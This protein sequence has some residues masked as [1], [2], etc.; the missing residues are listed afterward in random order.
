MSA[1]AKPRKKKSA[2][3]HG[4]PAHESARGTRPHGPEVH[5][6]NF[7]LNR[8]ER[9]VQE[10]IT[11]PAGIEAGMQTRSARKLIDVPPEELEK[12]ILPS[13]QLSAAERIGIYSS[14]YF[15]RL[16]E[17][18]EKDFEVVRHAVGEKRFTALAG[19]FLGKHPST[20]Y[21]LNKLGEK[22]A[23]FLRKEV[24]TLPHRSFIVEVAILERTIQDLFDERVATPLTVDDLLSVRKERWPAIKLKTIPALRLMKFAYP[25]NRYLQAVFNKKPPRKIPP[26]KT[27]WLAAY[28]KSFRVWRSDISLE[29]Y[30]LLSTIVAGKPLG[31]ALEVCAGL[32]GA[33]PQKL[34]ESIGPW[35][36]DWAADGIFCAIG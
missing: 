2:P 19:D 5:A 13:K 20:Y 17:I 34:A 24:K 29:Q 8:T 25:V 26:R 18:L 36:K 14:M 1:A 9:W 12:V 33:N 11:H 16:V 6:T 27:T 10:V 32:K 28:R 22:F 3:W 31:E 23:D 4:R 21:S 15:L 35:F 30:T 7:D